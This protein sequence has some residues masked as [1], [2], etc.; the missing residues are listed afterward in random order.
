MN[1][2]R[3]WPRVRS[4]HRWLPGEFVT[5]LEESSFRA[6]YRLGEV[7]G[8]LGWQVWC[9]RADPVLVGARRLSLFLML[10]S[11]LGLGR[12][13]GHRLAGRDGPHP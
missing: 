2:H 6:C 5:N 9:P 8:P 1:E 7:C 12:W 11:V 10:E 13:F 4:G 3:T